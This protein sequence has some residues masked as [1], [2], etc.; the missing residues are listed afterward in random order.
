MTVIKKM[1]LENFRGDRSSTF[2][3]AV[4]VTVILHAITVFPEL[5]T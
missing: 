1:V 4:S 3:S 5:I 2:I